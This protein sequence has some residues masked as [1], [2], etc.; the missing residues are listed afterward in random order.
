MSPPPVAPRPAAPTLPPRSVVIAGAGIGGL[1]AALALARR[2]IATKVLER[3]P[4]FGEDGA[5]IQLGPNGTRI[6]E[7]LGVAEFLRP[8][9]TAPDALRILDSATGRKLATLPLGRWIALRHGAPFWA[10]HRRDLHGALLKAAEREPLVSIRYACDVTLV[11]EG[12]DGDK[13]FSS[14]GDE[15]RGE[16]LVAADGAWSSLRS[17]AFAGAPPL[18]TGRSA[19]RTV[20]PI[21]DVPEAMNRTE[22]HLW[23]GPDVHVVHYP[24]SAG[25]AVALVAIFRDERI[26]GDWSAPCDS[27][28]VA[29]RSGG[30]TPLLRELLARPAEWRRWSLMTLPVTARIATGRLALLGDAAHPVQPFLA[31]GGAMA[32]EDAVV[33]AD[34]MAADPEP[35]RALAAYAAS[36]TSRVRRV[37]RASGVNGR[38]YHL[39]GWAASAR[40]L[41]L[42]RLA[43]ETL[44]RRLDWLYGWRLPSSVAS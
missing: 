10:A 28:W 4:V 36:R 3:R 21:G 7:A 15:I 38:I 18:Y 44:M 6:L 14:D 5:G 12:S 43:P 41:A 37:A 32:L 40:D 20:I 29:A 31:Q 30:F 23:L 2:G 24:V 1:A 19:V 22:V 9:V 16:A 35:A 39:G 11:R 27:A 13:A 25:H 17:R 34:A 26:A 33:L 8:R 42:T